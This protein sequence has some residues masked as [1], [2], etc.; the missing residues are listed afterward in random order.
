ML[1]KIPGYFSQATRTP[2]RNSALPMQPLKT[3][4]FSAPPEPQESAQQDP[5][6]G[7]GWEMVYAEEDQDL[8]TTEPASPPSQREGHHPSNTSSSNH[9][10]S[11]S[12]KHN[13]SGSSWWPLFNQQ[14]DPIKQE[15]F[16]ATRLKID[17]E[18]GN[19]YTGKIRKIDGEDVPHGQGSSYMSDNNAIMH[20]GNWK[21]GVPHGPGTR[22]INCGGKKIN[23]THQ[24]S[25]V[26]FEGNFEN[27]II[28]DRKITLFLGDFYRYTGSIQNT[29]NDKPID[30]ICFP[31]K[32]EEKKDG[33]WTTLHELK[34]DETVEWYFFYSKDEKKQ[35][36]CIHISSSSSP[37]VTL[38]PHLKSDRVSNR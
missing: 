38:E 3:S 33:Q 37:L 30:D 15:G 25:L 19:Y 5:S 8:K 32:F 4:A 36:C 28:A 1:T 23:D 14:K 12:S 21:N 20:E 31:G 26:R 7:D 6:N 34:E 35:L 18:Y 16:S 2:D 11:L 22:Y 29:K 13:T 17:N 27:G 9:N 24:K 10:P